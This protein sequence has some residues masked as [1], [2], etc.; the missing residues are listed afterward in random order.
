LGID[1][2]IVRLS[3]V[4]EEWEDETG[5]AKF[6]YNR[7]WEIS[8]AEY[9]EV[10]D[11]LNDEMGRMPFEEF[12]LLNKLAGKEEGKIMPAHIDFFDGVSEFYYTKYLPEDKQCLTEIKNRPCYK[13]LKDIVIEG[14][15]HDTFGSF[16]D[17][18]E[19]II[20]TIL[21]EYRNG[22]HYAIVYG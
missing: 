12:E 22:H 13:Y 6:F 5:K 8:E 16:I 3:D 15:Y 20:E 14:R 17:L 11:E 1:W 19:R 4:A 7:P 9:S 21:A 10:I 2:W 18:L